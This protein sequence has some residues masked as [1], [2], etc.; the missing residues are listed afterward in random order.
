MQNSTNF[1]HKNKKIKPLEHKEGNNIG[2]SEK[3]TEEVEQTS[4]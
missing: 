1:N 2:Q 3:S 4:L